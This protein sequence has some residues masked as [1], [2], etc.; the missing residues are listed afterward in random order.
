ML[1]HE[2]AWDLVVDWL[3]E[4][5]PSMGPIVEEHERTIERSFSWCFFYQSKKYV[6]TKKP[7][8]VLLGSRP[9][10]VNKFTREILFI[11]GRGPLLPFIEDYERKF[12]ETHAF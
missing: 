4:T 10:L 11:R 7:R 12:L 2:E 1:T 3:R 5:T 6:E 9:I 8:Y